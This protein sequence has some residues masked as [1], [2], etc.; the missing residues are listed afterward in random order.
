MQHNPKHMKPKCPLFSNVPNW[1]PT[2]GKFTELCKPLERWLLS[3]ISE[4]RLL[5]QKG[6]SHDILHRIENDS[7]ILDLCLKI[8]HLRS[9]NLLLCDRKIILLKG[10]VCKID[11]APELCNKI[12][13]L[14]E[15]NRNKNLT[16][17]LGDELTD[18]H[19]SIWKNDNSVR[20]NMHLVHSLMKRLTSF[21]DKRHK[22][23]FL[24]SAMVSYGMSLSQ[25]RLNLNEVCCDFISEFVVVTK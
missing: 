4:H 23:H 7:E 3:L 2:V 8:N 24:S 16:T 21:H 10:E 1:A 5:R 18:V 15:M 17:K 9:I 12:M 14:E 19:L 13:H 25:I 20:K 11:M 6:D 22:I